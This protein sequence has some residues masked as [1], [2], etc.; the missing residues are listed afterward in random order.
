MVQTSEDVYRQRDGGVDEVSVSA[1]SHR[2][3]ILFAAAAIAIAAAACGGSSQSPDAAS[4]SSTSA[5]DTAATP[6][7]AATSAAPGTPASGVVI[8]GSN[9]RFPKKG[10]AVDVP[11][12]WTARPD[13]FLDVTANQFS[14]DA[15][16]FTA[17]GGENQPSIIIACLKSADSEQTVDA[18]R[19]A[20]A[21]FIAQIAK[22]TAAPRPARIGD[23]DGFA[24]DF[25]QE[26]AASAGP[27]VIEQTAAGAIAGGCRWLVTLAA[28]QGQRADHAAEF[29]AVLQSMTF[30]P[31]E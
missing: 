20:R 15:L 26:L 12:G 25:V 5:P 30:F 7:T 22:S 16:F 31:P 14:T 4:P 1:F 6:G 9:Y 28:L 13:Y 11:Q 21:A 19:D 24:I 23:R 29:D 27:I 17:G 18:F 10:Y 2:L 8:T 3:L